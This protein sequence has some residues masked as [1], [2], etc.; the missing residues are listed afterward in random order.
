M[1]ERYP[2]DEHEPADGPTVCHV[3]NSFGE[4]TGPA[5]H[6]VALERHT[7]VEA[8]LLGWFAEG[9]FD[10]ADE[11]RTHCLNAPDTIVGVDRTTVRTALDFLAAYDLVH[12]HHPHSA[13][14]AKLLA[15]RLDIPSVF[16]YGTPSFRYSRKGRITNGLTN[17]LASAVT[18][19]S[20]A[21]RDSLHRWER[22][23][24][25]PDS[26]EVVYTGVDTKAVDAALDTDASPPWENIPSDAVTVGHAG[27][28]I[29]TKEQDVLVRAIAK[30]NR[31]L[32]R[33]CYLLIA[34]NGERRS[35]LERIAQEENIGARVRFLGFIPREDTYRLMNAVDV[36]AM[37]SRWEGFSSAAA[38]AMS[39][40]TPCIFSDISSF[41]EP[42]EGAARFH[43]VGDANGLSEQLV[44]LLSDEG[45]RERLGRLSH[46]RIH[47]GFTVEDTARE[48]ASI[49]RRVLKERST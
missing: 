1:S 21:V 34:G 6:A 7:D 41:T 15:R 14:F 24:I 36:F 43:P 38:E 5:N 9:T 11:I 18:A 33:D 2:S 10:G 25:R 28:L 39:V 22:R 16:T 37:P 31:Q 45:E 48:Y 26:V 20:P 47:D 12:A 17:R 19:V 27:R 23:C 46:Q 32:E 44:D 42:F 29:P 8:G 30:V 4:T 13:T 3:V 35:D 49:Y 40:G